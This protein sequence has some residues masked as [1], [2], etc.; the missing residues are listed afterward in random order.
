M[1]NRE[2][3]QI[4]NEL[5]KLYD[6]HGHGDLKTRLTSKSK[7]SSKIV[8]TFN[9][10]ISM[11]DNLIFKLKSSALDSIS[12]NKK[13]ND[14]ASVVE[15]NSRIIASELKEIESRMQNLMAVVAE[16]VELGNGISESSNKIFNQIEAQSSAVTQSSAA[17]TQMV[18]SIRNITGTSN[19]RLSRIKHLKEIANNSRVKISRNEDIIKTVAGNAD[20]IQTFISIINNIASQTN[21]LAMNAAIEAAHAGDA[22]RGF[23]VVA[24]EVRKLAGNTEINAKNIS[25]NLKVVTDGIRE[26]QNISADVTVSYNEILEDVESFAD[27][28]AEITRGLAE[29]SE[30]TEEIDKALSELFE[31]TNEVESSSQDV[32]K[33]SSGIADSIDQ[34]GKLA[35]ENTT[36]IESIGDKVEGSEVLIKDLSEICRKNQYELQSL[37]LEVEKV[38]ITDFSKLHSVDNQPLI[39]WN[40][41]KKD[42]PSRPANPKALGKLDPGY[43]RD[44][45]FACFNIKKESMPKSP[46]NGPKGKRIAAFV[47]GNHPY[48]KAY[49]QGMKKIADM[50]GMHLEVSEG[51][52]TTGPQKTFFSKALN[53]QYDMVIAIPADQDHFEQAAIEAWKKKVPLIVSQESPSVQTYKYILSFTGFDDWGTHRIFGKHFANTMNKTGGYAV[54]GHQDGSGHHIARSYAFSSEIYSYAPEME[55][56]ELEPSNLDGDKTRTMVREWLRKYEEKLKGIFVADGLVPLKAVIEVCDEF[57]RND[58]IIYTTGNNK[59]SLEMAKTGKCRGIRWE[60]AEADGAIAIETAVN[61]FNGLIVEPIRYLPMHTITSKDADDYLPAQW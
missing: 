29:L 34:I 1:K 40:S 27:S 25:A 5:G 31:I 19:E 55:L 32:N 41:F 58:I 18:A 42:I 30:G 33:K 16:S 24:D 23:S 46:G 26:A 20:Q 12:T 17:V 11:M 52:W 43:W 13:L 57:S 59:Y 4:E 2:Q 49:Q 53:S 50:M 22:G 6:A 38:K 61:W 35:N 56:L 60:S 39:L 7:S 28:V 8:K 45:E 51:D 44:E 14:K 36:F 10:V 47:A 15:N 54:V 21:L 3:V 48:Y 9:M 37:M